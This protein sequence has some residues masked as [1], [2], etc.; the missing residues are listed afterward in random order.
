MLQS[1]I[2]AFLEYCKVSDFSAKSIQSLSIRL[3]E[4]NCF[5]NKNPPDSIN[6]IS[7][8]D[9]LD[10]TTGH[11]SPSVHVKK[12]RVWALRQFYHYLSLHDVIDEN[13]ASGLRYPKI[14][15]TVPQY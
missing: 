6:G 7:F 3:E 12:A 14:E 9:L 2:T 5:L 1:Q 13:I 4:F 15:K 10:F 11:N 8:N